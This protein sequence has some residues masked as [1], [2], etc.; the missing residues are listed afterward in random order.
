MRRTLNNNLGRCYKAVTRM[1]RIPKLLSSCRSE[2][3]VQFHLDTV[4]FIPDLLP[5]LV[6]WI[7]TS[8]HR[9]L[10]VCV[11]SVPFNPRPS[12]W[13]FDVVVEIWCRAAP[14]SGNQSH[15]LPRGLGLTRTVLDRTAAITAGDNDNYH[16]LSGKDFK[17]HVFQWSRK[18]M[19]QTISN[20][21]CNWRI[22]LA[23]Q[24]CNRYVPGGV[25]YT[26][27]QVGHT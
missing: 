22:E 20:S 14:H 11:L 6:T 2:R 9:R 8:R 12:Q 15:R 16:L 23:S 3:A 17:L 18:D 1:N 5:I 21:L 13:D 24:S 27:P 7:L 25:V 19:A 10:I 26:V 4:I